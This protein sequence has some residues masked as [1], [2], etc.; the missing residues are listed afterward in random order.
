MLQGHVALPAT[1]AADAC[2]VADAILGAIEE[3][4]QSGEVERASVHYPHADE[5]DLLG[6]EI[7]QQELVDGPG[8]NLFCHRAADRLF[9]APEHLCPFALREIQLIA[10]I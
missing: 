9:A 2:I 6:A 8:C 3:S 5:L 10:S 1:A 7:D 4:L